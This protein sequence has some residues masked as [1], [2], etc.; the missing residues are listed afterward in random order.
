MA[1]NPE[2]P[3]LLAGNLNSVFGSPTLTA[4]GKQWQIPGAGRIWPTT[5][6]ADPK[7]QIDFVLSHPANRWKVVEV[8]VIE[9]TVAS[10]HRPILVRFELLPSPSATF[11][12]AEAGVAAGIAR[13][14]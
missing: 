4:L 1:D 10:D 8:R 7:R 6:V 12:P 14:Q 5:P 13:K 2:M 3:T 11:R 9:E